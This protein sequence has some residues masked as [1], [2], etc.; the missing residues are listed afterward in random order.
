MVQRRTRGAAPLLAVAHCLYPAL[1]GD[2]AQAASCQTADPFQQGQQGEQQEFWKEAEHLGACQWFGEGVKL[3]KLVMVMVPGSVEDERMFSAKEN[4]RNPQR[5]RLKQ[6]HLTC[7]ARGFK[8]PDIT[9]ESFPYAATI[10]EW[11]SVRKRHG[12]K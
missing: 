8:C 4:L 9:V 12:I 2:L 7:C 5:K 6:Q 10:G 3:A 1:E 11:L